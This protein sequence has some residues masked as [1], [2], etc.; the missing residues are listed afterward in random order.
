MTDTKRLQHRS[1]PSQQQQ[2]FLQAASCVR[3]RQ[4]DH[5]HICNPRTNNPERETDDKR[6]RL[7]CSASGWLRQ[8]QKQ[9]HQ[10]QLKLQ[11]CCMER[12]CKRPLQTSHIS[13]LSRWPHCRKHR[14]RKPM[15]RIRWNI[16]LASPP[17][18]DPLLSQYSWS[19]LNLSAKLIT[20]RSS[21]P[22][23]SNQK[24]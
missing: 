5:R 4:A 23:K 15:S 24:T 8:S 16:L 20:H 12:V 17:Q 18:N 6:G 22:P 11:W 7:I 1:A 19:L 10:C 14:R 13:Q 2:Q 3:R 9:Q 21:G